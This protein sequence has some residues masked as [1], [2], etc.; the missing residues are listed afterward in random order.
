MKKC[1]T[2]GYR[3]HKKLNT[4][5]IV[6]CPNRKKPDHCLA[7]VTCRI[8]TYQASIL[9]CLVT[10]DF[11]TYA[12]LV[13]LCFIFSLFTFPALGL[14]GWIF[15][16]HTILFVILLVVYLVSSRALDAAEEKLLWIFAAC[17]TVHNILTMI[18]YY[19]EVQDTLL[20]IWIA[21][22]ITHYPF[23]NDVIAFDTSFSTHMRNSRRMNL[24]ITSIDCNAAVWKIQQ[25][26]LAQAPCT[27]PNN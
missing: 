20:F 27:T 6:Y 15:T 21:T 12:W 17:R 22:A 2:Q 5:S 14:K 18:A 7:K 9:E 8:E 10:R 24:E 23:M 13:H 19:Y 11:F 26:K 4:A 16:T 3:I 1:H 25:V